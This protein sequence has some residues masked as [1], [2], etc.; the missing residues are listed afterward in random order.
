MAP[1]RK[2]KLNQLGFFW[3]GQK[4]EQ[5]WNDRFAELEEFKKRFGHCRVSQK[6][7]NQPLANW[8]HTQ[9]KLLK[10]GRLLPERKEKLLAIGFTD[11]PVTMHKSPLTL[12]SQAPEGRRGN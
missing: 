5:Q 4:Q 2:E 3:F 7:E 1:H 11:Q 9:R 8:V 10:A 12:P 6:W